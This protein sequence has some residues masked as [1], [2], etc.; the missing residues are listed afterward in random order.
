MD[1]GDDLEAFMTGIYA[2][3]VPCLC[4]YPGEVMAG[5]KVAQI[6]TSL[7]DDGNRGYHGTFNYFDPDNFFTLSAIMYSGDPYLQ[8]QARAVLERTGSLIKQD[9]GMLPHHF[10]GTSP[11]YVALSGERQTGPNTFWTKA[12]LRYAALTGDFDWLASYMPTLRSA[13]SF[14]F[15]LVDSEEDLVFAP[16][17]LMIDVFVRNNFTADTNA[18]LVGFATD[19]AAAERRVGNS[20]GAVA[21]DAL[22]ERVAAAVNNKLWAPASA[23]GDHLI[24]QLNRDGTTRD[25]VD[26]GAFASPPHPHPHPHPSALV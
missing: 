4:T 24:T 11:T 3:A 16:G 7:R 15:N 12:A 19:F 9:S 25:F 22:A 1:N 10:A 6:A 18:M 14:V 23:G 20:T 2:S 8:A 21:L 26:Y 5:V 17:S 13:A